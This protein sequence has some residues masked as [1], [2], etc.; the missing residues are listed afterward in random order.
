LS[1]RT[2]A[3]ATAQQRNFAFDV[4]SAQFQ[5]LKTGHYNPIAMAEGRFMPVSIDDNLQY[6]NFVRHYTRNLDKWESLSPGSAVTTSD[7]SGVWIGLLMHGP[8]G[9]ILYVKFYANPTHKPKWT[10]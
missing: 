6:Y 3:A 2:V 1:D 4:A 10:G 9:A 7:N 8:G 5:S